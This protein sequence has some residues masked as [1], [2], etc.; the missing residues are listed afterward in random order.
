MSRAAKCMR[1]GA[2]VRSVC[3]C[4]CAMHTHT[5]CCPAVLHRKPSQIVCVLLQGALCTT[6]SLSLSQSF[7]GHAYKEAQAV[8]CLGM[9]DCN[10]FLQ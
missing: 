9:T 7:D 8:S 4:C 6:E 10:E 1:C 2:V 5:T 3:R